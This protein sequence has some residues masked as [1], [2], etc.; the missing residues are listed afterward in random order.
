MSD[1][2]R[3]Q[4]N[5]DEVAEKINSQIGDVKT[6]LTD[7]VQ[8]LSVQTHAFIIDKANKELHGFK[9]EQFL[10]EKNRNIRWSQISERIWVVEI[11]ES[12]R[13]IEEGREP[14]SMATEAWLL[15][16]DKV[17]TAKDG[18]KY[19]AIPFTQSQG[20]G[21]SA[22]FKNPMPEVEKEIKLILKKNNISLRKVE[23]DDNGQPKLGIIHKLKVPNPSSQTKYLK[24]AGGKDWFSPPRTQEQANL[25]GL[26]AHTGIFQGKGAVVVQRKGPKGGIVKE[27]I[28]FRTVSSKHQTEGRWM[29]PQV[30]PFNSMEAAYQWARM[31]WDRI[32]QMLS[33]SFKGDQPPSG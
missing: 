13:W 16:G 22:N 32:V 18:S 5:V 1:W 20:K 21:K 14:T 17:K 4:V 33:D 10:G 29:Y 31:E 28:T 27:V 6:K 19:R 11:D 8:S 9:R 25:S 24:V 12:V 23:V 2:F 30:T 7:A 3:F 26:K 15:K